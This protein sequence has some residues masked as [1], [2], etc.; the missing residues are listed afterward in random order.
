MASQ[1]DKTIPGTPSSTS[2]DLSFDQLTFDAEGRFTTPAYMPTTSAVGLQAADS[3]SVEPL[4]P[5]T[6]RTLRRR[7]MSLELPVFLIIL[8]SMLSGAVMLNQE[9]YQTCVAVFH[10]NESDCEPLRG[11]IPK[12]KEAQIIEK[13]LQPYVAKISMTGSMLNNVWPGILVLFVG[14]WSDKFGR[15][16]VLLV[17]FT[18]M[19]LGHVIN[20]IL[21][22]FSKALTLNP[23]F[24]LLANVPSTLVGGG[25]SM[26]TIVF[27]Y[28]SDVSDMENKAKR[29]FYVDMVMGLGV[30]IG[31]IISSYLLRLTNAAIVCAT[32]A[33]L[34]FIAL[35]YILF[36]IGE[37]LAVEETSFAHKAKH[38]FDVRLIK[39]LA[40]TCVTRRPDYGRAIIGCTISILIVSNFAF[41]GEQ[42]VFYLF[43]RNK[44]NVTLQQYTYYN[45][46]GITIKMVGCAVA[47]GVFRN[48]LKISFSAIAMMGLFGCILDSLT[49]A[50]AQQFWQMYIASSL[51]LMSGITG[52]MLQSIVS[53]AVP[54]NEIGKI[55]SLASCLQTISPLA[56]APLYTLVYNST[57]NFYP[58]LYNYIS[59]GLHVECLCVM[60]LIYIFE[61]RVSKRTNKTDMENGDTDRSPTDNT[62]TQKT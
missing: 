57:L 22:S 15:R 25:C 17:T 59:T 45:A 41:S 47:F 55:Y 12:T 28:I 36:F 27:C 43:L 62:T 31:N 44:F 32:S 6:R 33:T 7:I 49:R 52:P 24:Y 54:S 58:G 9:L 18:A 42:G 14:P 19:F 53:L 10:Y 29:M 21:V 3:S 35:M 37:S 20:T 2:T 4:T 46:V 48:L 1:G 38:F 34:V 16:P 11:I 39:D 51:G 30:V 40:K 23:W 56:S 5:Q 26:I 13:S 61:R 50:L 8:A 60:I